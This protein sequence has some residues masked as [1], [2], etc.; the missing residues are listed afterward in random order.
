MSPELTEV[1]AELRRRGLAAAT[2]EAAKATGRQLERA[3]GVS[4]AQVS[5]EQVEAFV[6]AYADRAP[7]T[8]AA[9]VVRLRMLFGALGEREDGVDLSAALPVV[10]ATS[11]PQRVLSVEEVRQLLLAASDVSRYRPRN[12]VLALRDRACLELLYGLGL[13]RSE[14]GRLGVNDLRLAEASVVVR[15]SKRVSVEEL[16]LP[17][18]AVAPLR[19]YLSEGRPRLAARS[20]ASAPEFLL[21]HRGR[22]LGGEGVRQVVRRVARAAGFRAAPHDCRR[23][24]ATHLVKAGANVEVVRQVLGHANLGAT[25]RYIR[26]GKEDL[27]RAVRVLDFEDA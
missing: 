25:A 17:Q 14:L 21:G 22:A 3:A 20:Q 16:P 24:L 7:A 18:G 10:R 5:R 15:R 8:Q 4:V 23:S 12:G 11:R 26:L 19:R 6:A 27:R 1:L 9:H 2:L 13:R